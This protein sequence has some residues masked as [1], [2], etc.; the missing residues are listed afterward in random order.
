[1][2]PRGE[3]PSS[4]PVAPSDQGL[5][6]GLDPPRSGVTEATPPSGHFLRRFRLVAALRYPRPPRSSVWLGVT[7][8]SSM[9]LGSRAS[10]RRGPPELRTARR[11]RQ[12]P[13]R[14]RSP[15]P[16]GCATSHVVCTLCPIWNTRRAGC[17]RSGRRCSADA[18]FTRLKVVVVCLND[19][20]EGE[21]LEEDLAW[22]AVEGC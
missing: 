5:S 7:A 16:L 9:S 21:G 4:S 22:L 3:A 14:R 2:P 10:T 13:R 20:K 19:V 12:R 8:S 11:P 17:A 18:L 1:M 15:P 6:S